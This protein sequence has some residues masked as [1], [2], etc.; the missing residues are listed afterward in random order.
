LTTYY[1]PMRMLALLLLPMLATGALA[2]GLSDAQRSAIKSACRSDY[3]QVCSSVPT[4]TQASL[5]CLVEHSAQVSSGCQSALAP[6]M[7][8]AAASAPAGSG[9]TSATAAT[10]AAA[11]ASA[12]PAPAMHASPR[13]E[14]RVLR[15]SCGADFQKLCAGVPLGGGRGIA[16]LRSHAPDLTPG[17]K[18][19]LASLAGAQ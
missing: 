16:C 5:Q 12:S 4:G 8:P 3:M 15:N 13:A 7:P 1:R 18:S 14:A 9:A 6:A 10:P 11:S 2:Q 19:A 17:C